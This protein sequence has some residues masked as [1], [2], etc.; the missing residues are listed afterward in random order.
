VSAAPDELLM[1]TEL[2]EAMLPVLMGVLPIALTIPVVMFGF[3]AIYRLFT[4][5]VPIN[6]SKEELRRIEEAQANAVHRELAKKIEPTE[7][8]KLEPPANKVHVE[9]RCKCAYCDPSRYAVRSVGL[10]PPNAGASQRAWRHYW[11]GMIEERR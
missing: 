4:Y 2:I 7:P 9:K 1:P 8:A 5:D 10:E 6:Y 11:D 3:K